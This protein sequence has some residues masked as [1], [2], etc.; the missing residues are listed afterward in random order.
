MQT[1]KKKT[2]LR[3][4]DK[5]TKAQWGWEWEGRQLVEE[6]TKLAIKDMKNAWSQQ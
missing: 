1:N 3:I 6:V 4:S 2:L 5:R